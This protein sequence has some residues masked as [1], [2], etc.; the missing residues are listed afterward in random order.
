MVLIDRPL[1]MALAQYMSGQCDLTTRIR[2]VVLSMK[3]PHVYVIY[4][5]LLAGVYYHV[6]T[7]DRVAD[8][9]SIRDLANATYI[10]Y[11]DRA[12]EPCWLY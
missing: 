11:G 6:S 2:R 7:D 5:R 9:V 8:V 3:E 10:G 12:S 4:R 1:A